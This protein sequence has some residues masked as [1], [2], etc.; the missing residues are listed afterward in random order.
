M[1]EPNTPDEQPTEQHQRPVAGPDATTGPAAEQAH[2]HP[3]TEQPTAA[4][5]PPQQASEQPTVAQP[6]AA[7]TT[8]QQPLP[9]YAPPPP[10]APQ[11]QVVYVQK[12]PGKFANFARNRVTQVVAALVVGLIVGGGIGGLIGSHHAV[13]PG[14]HRPYYQYGPG[15]PQR[16]FGPSQQGSTQQGSYT[17]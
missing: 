10:G 9:S 7:G 8:P 12:P 4:Q 14:V 16:G 11:P 3:V 13:G 5:V 2:Q 17:R 1:S 6:A 15:G